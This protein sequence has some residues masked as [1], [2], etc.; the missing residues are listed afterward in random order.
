MYDIE[1]MDHHGYKA[2]L[3]IK[4][5]SPSE[6]ERVAWSEVYEAQGPK[7]SLWSL[8]RVTRG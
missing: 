3:A 1:F 4:A 2:I 7:A 8:V 5:A 6:A